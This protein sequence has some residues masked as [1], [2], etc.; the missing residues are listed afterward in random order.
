MRRF[1]FVP[2]VIAAL[3]AFGAVG[4]MAGGTAVNVTVPSSISMTGLNATY[5]ATIPA[6][7]S[8]DIDAALTITTNN[9]SGYTL[10][11]AAVDPS[12]NNGVAPTMPLSVDVLSIGATFAPIAAIAQAGVIVKA[13]GVPTA[14]DSFTV[15]QSISVPAG[16]T[17]GLYTLNETFVAVANP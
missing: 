9:Y 4:A 14:G 11:V 16:Q 10:T 12:F 8:A 6:G 3:A 13:T 2:I 1:I 17:S 7:T 15:R 5:A